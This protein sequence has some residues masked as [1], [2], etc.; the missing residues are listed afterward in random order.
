MSPFKKLGIVALVA[1]AF[2]IVAV[3]CSGEDQEETRTPVMQQVAE[4]VAESV[5]TQVT[6]AAF[7]VADDTLLELTVEP[8]SEETIETEPA[9]LEPF[10]APSGQLIT[11]GNKTYI[12]TGTRLVIYNWDNRTDQ[13]IET[14]TALAAVAVH[15]EKVY[16]GGEG[17]YVLE[18]DQLVPVV[19][20]IEGTISSL[21]SFKYRLLV[22]TDQ[23]LYSRSVF[24]DEK[25]LPDVAI[26]AL[27][28]DDLGVWV[29]TAGD[30]L[31]RWNGVD[32]KARYLARDRSL[33]AH[34]TALDFGKNHLYVGTPDGLFIY[35]GGRWEEKTAA[36]G[37]PSGA[38]TALDA[39]Y[40]VVAIGTD[41]GVATFFNEEFDTVG[42]LEQTRAAALARVDKQ[43]LVL[44]DGG[45]L[46]IKVGPAVRPLIRSNPTEK[47]DVFSGL[48]DH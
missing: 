43:L 5:A 8:V 31:Y 1:F 40:W 25:L 2:G 42:P 48:S 6:E 36:D 26:S 39:S 38:I 24:G 34:V 46:K 37:L 21:L 4:R 47:I 41:A 10:E 11:I 27:A 45:E 23:G 13:T 32:F 19:S 35:D 28:S 14:E 3:G 12:A 22:G 44:T 29:G 30:G 16:V 20:E 15:A 18:N 7:A 9:E 33:M 17:L